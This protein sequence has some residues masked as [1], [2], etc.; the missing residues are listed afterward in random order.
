ME[1]RDFAWALMELKKGNKVYRT[2]W[3]GKGMFLYLVAGCK[4]PVANLRGD[5]YDAIAGTQKAGSNILIHGHID[6]KAADGLIMVGWSPSQMDMF[7]DDWEV[8]L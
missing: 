1:T 2:G 7:A 4:L 3:N 5:A 8:V 6:M